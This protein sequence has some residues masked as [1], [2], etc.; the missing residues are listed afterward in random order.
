M[1]RMRGLNQDDLEVFVYGPNKVFAVDFVDGTG[2]TEDFIKGWAKC[3]EWTSREYKSAIYLAAP[4]VENEKVLTYGLECV[5][6]EVD[7]SNGLTDIPWR[8]EQV[9]SNTFH[10]LFL[11][12]SPEVL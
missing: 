2:A 8:N 5:V 9:K 10:A 4:F 1:R 3:E 12:G 7:R 6:N 11:S